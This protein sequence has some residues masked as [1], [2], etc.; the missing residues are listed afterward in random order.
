M[1]D[2]TQNTSPFH[3]RLG[4]RDAVVLVEIKKQDSRIKCAMIQFDPVTPVGQFLKKPLVET[5]EVLTGARN[6]AT[7]DLVTSQETS[8]LFSHSSRFQ[9]GKELFVLFDP[10]QTAQNQGVQLQGEWLAMIKTM[11]DVTMERR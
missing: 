6:P 11:I 3:A 2:F 7:V 9:E 5:G 1:G 4:V 8:K 10:C